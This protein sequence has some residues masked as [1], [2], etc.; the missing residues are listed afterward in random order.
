M[1]EL[2]LRLAIEE[3][4]KSSSPDGY[5]VGAVIVKGNELLSK[6]YSG[7]SEEFTHAEELAIHKCNFQNLEGATIYTTMEPC[8]LRRSG[9]KSCCDW[10]I[11]SRIKRVVFGVHDPDT[12]VKCDGI[13][14]LA[15][16]GLELLHLKSLENRCKEL[17]PNLFSS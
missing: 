9:K 15:N 16:V 3:A 17:T 2:Y 1:D 12:Y 10:I 4:E 13:E 11:E 8:D 14:K 6:A 5:R 7:E